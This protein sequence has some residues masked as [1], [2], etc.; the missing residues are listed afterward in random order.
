MA[1]GDLLLLSPV[2]TRSHPPPKQERRLCSSGKEH[3]QYVLSHDMTL[4]RACAGSRKAG[5][6]RCT[7]DCR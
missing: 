6:Q 5:H 3:L 4:T 2:H 1:G 7:V